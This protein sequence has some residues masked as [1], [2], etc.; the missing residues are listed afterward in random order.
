MCG[1][2]VDF[3]RAYGRNEQTRLDVGAIRNRQAKTVQEANQISLTRSVGL[4]E[5]PLEVSPHGV[6]TDLQQVGNFV[7]GAPTGQQRGH[8]GLSCR[9][10]PELHQ[11]LLRRLLLSLRIIHQKQAT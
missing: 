4:H 10:A 3:L 11:A 6:N 5:Y 2:D 9:Q 7:Q 1:A 8:S